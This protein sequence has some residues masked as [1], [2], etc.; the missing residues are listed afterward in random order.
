MEIEKYEALMRMIDNEGNVI[1]P[2]F[3]LDI[4]KKSRIYRQLTK[5]MINKSFAEFKD[6][7]IKFSINL[8]IEDIVDP[9]MC[10]YISH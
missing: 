7:D 2:F 9:S 10:T 6:K 5:I 8:S 3:F 4:A 1:S